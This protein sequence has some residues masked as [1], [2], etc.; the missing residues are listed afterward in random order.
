MDLEQY[1]VLKVER[2]D[3]EAQID[4]GNDDPKLRDRLQ[5]IRKALSSDRPT[6]AA[7]YGSITPTAQPEAAIDDDDGGD[8]D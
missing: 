6:L 8:G 3:I 7:A 1:E 4:S 2:R 5:E